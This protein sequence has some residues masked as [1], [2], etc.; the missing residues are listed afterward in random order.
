MKVQEIKIKETPVE[1][2]GWENVVE[3]TETG[4]YVTIKRKVFLSDSEVKK[5]MGDKDPNRYFRDGKVPM[6]MPKSFGTLLPEDRTETIVK[7]EVFTKYPETLLFKHDLTNI[8]TLLI[9]KELTEHEFSNGDFTDRLVRY[10]TRSIVFTGG[11]GRP[12][13]FEVDY[14]KKQSAKVLQSLNK[15]AEERKVY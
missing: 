2:D 15:M 12:S 1:Y 8:Y 3:P 6:Y 11:P 9:P 7:N 10:D 14:F 13:S 5:F 4:A